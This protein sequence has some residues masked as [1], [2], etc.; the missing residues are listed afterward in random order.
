MKNMRLDIHN[1]VADAA[2]GKYL[3]AKFGDADGD[4]D[5]A[6]AA[7]DALLGVSCD[8]PAGTGERVDVCRLGSTPVIYGGNV[9]R[10]QYLTAGAGGKAVAITLP[11]AEASVQVI[12]KA[13]VSGV[14]DDIGSVYV[15]PF[16]IYGGG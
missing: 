1:F 7:T 4:A 14:A 16:V 8:V 5:L 13:E 11:A 9:T 15:N 10:G 6:T 12:G 3:V 2:I